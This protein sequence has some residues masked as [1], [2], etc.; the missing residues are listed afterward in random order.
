MKTTHIGV[1]SRDTKDTLSK[2]ISVSIRN[3]N[4]AVFNFSFL[5]EKEEYRG[6]VGYLSKYRCYWC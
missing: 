1:E 5:R 6:Y 3:A 4:A 2:M